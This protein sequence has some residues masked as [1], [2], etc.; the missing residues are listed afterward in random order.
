MIRHC[1]MFRW[2]DGVTDDA[3]QAIRAGLDRLAALDC[4]AG[5]VHG[6][7]AGLVEGNFDYAVVGDFDSIEDYHEYAAEA[8]HRMLIEEWIKPNI[9][10]R[11]AV[12]FEC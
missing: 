5:Y 8:G 1:V 3:I 2:A 9:A 12:Q 7:D 10:A 11:A 4:V 6:P